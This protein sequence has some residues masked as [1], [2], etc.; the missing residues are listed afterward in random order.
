MIGLVGVIALASLPIVV[1]VTNDLLAQ[2]GW[3][4]SSV[5]G[6]TLQSSPQAACAYIAANKSQH[7]ESGKH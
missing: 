3:R 2:E 5:A 4:A 6:P 7:A 1:G